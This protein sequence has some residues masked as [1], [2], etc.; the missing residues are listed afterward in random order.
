MHAWCV[1]PNHVHALITPIERNKIHDIT[2]SWKS[3]TAKECN[4]ILARTGPFWQ[5]ES[6]DRYIRNARHYRNA[7]RYIEHNPVNAGL[8]EKPEDWAWSSARLR[9]QS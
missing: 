6:F 9:V 5:R 1:M 2:Q 4:R 8:C 7:L 3:F